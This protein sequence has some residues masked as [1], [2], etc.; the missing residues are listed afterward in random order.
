MQIR[1]LIPWNWGGRHGVG[2]PQE[3]RN[4]VS[5][6]QGEV[7]RAFESFWRS[8]EAPLV[9]TGSTP[10]FGGELQPRVEV[11]ENDKEIEVAAE[12]PG[13]NDKDIEIS[14]TSD[15]LTIRGEKRSGREER[16][17]DYFLSERTYGVIQRTIPLPGNVDTDKVNATFKDG[18][19]R[20]V[21]PK[22]ELSKAET[23]SIEIKR[24]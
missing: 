1:D 18:V 15:T 13:M 17:C 8:F 6:L 5:A 4:P 16:R 21:L 20:V 19:L 14:L 3:G 23:R 12:L 2:A 9:R 10:A 7:N 22:K 11:A 24:E